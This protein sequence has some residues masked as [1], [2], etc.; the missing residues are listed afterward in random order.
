[1]TNLKL[2]ETSYIRLLFNRAVVWTE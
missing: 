1:M 2:I